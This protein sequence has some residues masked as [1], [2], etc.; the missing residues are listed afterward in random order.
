MERS[1]LKKYLLGI[2]IGTSSCKI[3]L[4][5]YLG[6]II[7]EVSKTYTTTY[8]PGGKVYQNASD[9]YDSVC[10][11]T[12]SLFCDGDIKAD[13]IAGIGI[14]GMSWS[15]VAVDIN[16]NPLFPVSIWLDSSSS[17][18]VSNWQKTLDQRS[19]FSN[20]GNPLSANY[21]TA[22][23]YQFKLEHPELYHKTHYFLQSNS[24]LVYKLTDIFSQDYSQSYALHFFDIKKRCFNTQLCKQFGLDIEKFPKLYESF[25]VVGEVSL[26][27]AK[28]T[29]LFPGTPVVAGGLDAACATLG[30]G[31]IYE[32]QT[33]EQGGQAEGMSICTD[34]CITHPQLICSCHVIPNKWLLQ[35]GTVGGGNALRW[36][37]ESVIQNKEEYVEL[38]NRAS[39]IAPGCDGMVF[40]PYLQGERSPIWDNSAKGLFFGIDYQSTK[41]HFIRSIMEGVAFSL[42][43][44]IETAK[45][46]GIEV[47]QLHAMGGSSKSTVWMQIKADITGIPII[48]SDCQNAT[49]LG[50][51]L[52]AGIGVGIYQNA[53]D[54][55]TKTIRY[56]QNIIPNKSNNSLYSL[57]YEKYKKLYKNTKMI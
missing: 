57:I 32:N 3:A 40:L 25:A 53:T 37:K 5:D 28:E 23:I 13:E 10:K 26:H 6:N 52:L 11:A 55:V 46:S 42:R 9:W 8:L 39:N 33:Q 24:F 36:F 15:V 43:H 2:D 54:A 19:I 45:E 49:A 27:A 14:D 29:G 1:H 41:A 21:S 22:K 44:N 56:S 4:F 7:K 35:G 51:A 18:I 47:S 50:A 34:Q 16:G 48:I 20:S 12:E 38:D 17:D 30:V 31:V